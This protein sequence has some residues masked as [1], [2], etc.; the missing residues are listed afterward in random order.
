MDWADWVPLIIPQP[1]LVLAGV[2]VF[3]LYGIAFLRGR[4]I[5]GPYL[6]AVAFS[7]LPLALFYAFALIG[8]EDQVHAVAASRIAFAVLF[9]SN[10]AVGISINGARFGY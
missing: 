1:A 10:L 7:F 9:G 8:Y 2:A 5:A 6:V 4:I 3:I